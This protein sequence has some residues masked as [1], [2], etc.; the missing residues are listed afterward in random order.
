MKLY[1]APRTRAT[2]PRWMLEEL[3]VPYGLV[4]VSVAAPMFGVRVPTLVDGDVAL[5]GSGAICAYLA[6][7]FLDK[8]L[9]PRPGAPER[10]PYLQWLYYGATA[11]D[12]HLLDAA[13]ATDRQDPEA[14]GKAKGAF[15]GRVHVLNDAL[16]R[17][18]YLLGDA[19]TTVD[20]VLGSI[21]EGALALGLLAQR[22]RLGEYVARLTA[23]EGYRSA[24]AD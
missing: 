12:P 11:L 5:T 15:A 6:D 20:V 4:R 13:L 2:R 7:R 3:G 17:E 22:S 24:R 1:Y 23:R 8:G 14:L 19:F 9:A 10:G 21:V 18:G 16:N